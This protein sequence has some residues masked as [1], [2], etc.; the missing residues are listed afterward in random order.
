MTQLNRLVSQSFVYGA[1]QDQDQ[2]VKNIKHLAITDLGIQLMNF[3]KDNKDQIMALKFTDSIFTTID[4]LDSI[5]TYRA[6]IVPH[7]VR[8]QVLRFSDIKK[9]W[10]KNILNKILRRQIKR[11]F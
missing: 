9:P 7:R 11:T 6:E 4:G 8:E 10:Y 2:D 5:T 3:L 1:Y